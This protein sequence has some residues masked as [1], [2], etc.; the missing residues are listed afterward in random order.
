[1]PCSQA[2]RLT[3]GQ[4]WSC[5]PL[6]HSLEASIAWAR[7]YRYDLLKTRR[8]SPEA[9]KRATR[10]GLYAARQVADALLIFGVMRGD[11]ESLV[12]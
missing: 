4:A 9:R 3:Q 6:G 2:R 11:D 8:D 10:A 1:M 7:G 5:E 12:V